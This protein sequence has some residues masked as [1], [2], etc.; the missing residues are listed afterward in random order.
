MS[1][2]SVGDVAELQLEIR[3]EFPSFKIL[4][5][6][7]STLMRAIHWFLVVITFGS[8]RA[9]L[10]S[11]ITTIGYTVYVPTAWPMFNSAEQMEILRHERVHMRQRRRLSMPVFSF[12]YLFVLPFGLAF[13]RKKFEMEAYEESIRA[14]NEYGLDITSD[15]YRDRMV[16]HFVTSQ[17]IWMWP[18]KSSVLAWFEDAKKKTLEIR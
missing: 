2:V 1:T 12:L 13:F 4:R 10:I 9:F 17:Y 7:D 18:F 6:E 8:M 14:A 11:Y 15:A 5:K 16:A 3:A